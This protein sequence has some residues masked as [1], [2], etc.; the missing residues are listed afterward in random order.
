M[1]LKLALW[2]AYKIG[3][4]EFAKWRSERVRMGGKLTEHNITVRLENSDVWGYLDYDHK[5][6][7]SALIKGENK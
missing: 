4:Q 1:R 7:I 6:M 5:K 2:L 3:G